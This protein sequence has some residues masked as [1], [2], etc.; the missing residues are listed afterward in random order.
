MEIINPIN[1]ILN[2]CINLAS[3]RKPELLDN[4]VFH[5]YNYDESD[6]M[7]HGSNGTNT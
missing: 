2:E 7:E 4:S 5:A 3:M 1:D 6:R